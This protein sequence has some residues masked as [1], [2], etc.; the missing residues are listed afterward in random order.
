VIFQGAAEP[1]LMP[2]TIPAVGACPHS[3]ATGASSETASAIRYTVPA[4]SRKSPTS[5]PVPGAGSTDAARSGSAMKA[6]ARDINRYADGGGGLM[7]LISPV[8]TDLHG[9][10]GRGITGHLVAGERDPRVLAQ[11][12]RKRA[13]AKIS[14]LEEALEGAEFFTAR[15]AALLKAMPARTGRA[16]EDTAQLTS[17][18]CSTASSSG[19]I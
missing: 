12:A 4:S 19:I 16:G 2:G 11:L 18:R 15:H 1:L 14:Q 3:V 8:L 13:R 10:T 9:M 17:V 5:N 7:R 6:S